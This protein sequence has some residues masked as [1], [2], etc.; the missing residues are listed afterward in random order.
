MTEQLL[1]KNGAVV[2]QG[3][4]TAFGEAEISIAAVSNHLRFPGQ[5]YDAES[6]LHQNMYRDYDPSLGRYIQADPIGL[7]GRRNVYGYVKNR[8]LY[9]SDPL[10]LKFVYK[11]NVSPAEKKAFER[12]LQKGIDAGGSTKKMIEELAG[13]PRRF[14]LRFPKEGEKAEFASG[15]R[16]LI[17]EVICNP[18]N[19]WRNSDSNADPLPPE[20]QL[21][22]ELKHALDYLNDELSKYKSMDSESPGVDEAEARGVGQEND[23]YRSVNPGGS[24]RD[25]YE[26]GELS[27]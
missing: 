2:W 17:P 27:R 23:Y 22:H 14:L 3:E 9:F 8:P 25:N 13:S 20:G 5:Y 10:G 26:G 21:F 1:A 16:L 6:G 24:V 19:N 18:E 11:K 15:G 4:Y 12:A 7:A